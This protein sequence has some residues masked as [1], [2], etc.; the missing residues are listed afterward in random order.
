[1]SYTLKASVGFVNL[2][3]DAFHRFAGH[4]LK[5]Y[6]DFQSPHKFSPVPYFLLCRALELELKARHLQFVR[7]KVVKQQFSH[8]L[9]A[10]YNALPAKEKVLNQ[11]DLGLLARANAIYKGKGFE[12]FVPEHALRGYSNYPDLAALEALVCKYVKSSI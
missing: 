3:P 4:Y 8:N 9:E 5:C 1:M 7:Q 2:S 12:Y 11:A 6:R 10:A